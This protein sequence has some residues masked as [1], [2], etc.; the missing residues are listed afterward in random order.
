MA[1]EKTPKKPQEPGP[2]DEIGSSTPG[3]KGTLRIRVFGSE[4][5]SELD[6]V[7]R[8]RVT[9][10][11]AQGAEP[12]TGETDD[13]GELVLEVPSGRY[14]VSATAFG[15]TTTSDWIV[16]QPRCETCVELVLDINLD[17]GLHVVMTDVAAGETTPFYRSGTLLRLHAESSRSDAELEGAVFE[18]T[19][20]AGSF[21]EPQSSTARDVHLDTSGA[22]GPLELGLTAEQRADLE[23]VPFGC[24]FFAAFAAGWTGGIRPGGLPP[25][26]EARMVRRVAL[27][28][29]LGG[30]ERTRRI[31]QY[32]KGDSLAGSFT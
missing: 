13:K 27:A 8:A 31:E 28:R 5:K 19:A 9:V 32:L 2:G 4:G 3:A 21:L 22:R 25:E 23:H 26:V 29:I 14:Q 24:D 18:W 1:A 12:I 17:I 16:V 30:P 15:D 20:S 10:T 11:S 6:V 7:R